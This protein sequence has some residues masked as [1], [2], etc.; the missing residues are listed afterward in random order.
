MNFDATRTLS[1]IGAAVGALLLGGVLILLAGFDPVQAY[2]ALFSGA[3]LEYHGLASTLVKM[4]PLIL[5]GLAVAMPLRAGLFNIGAEGQIYLGGLLAAWVGLL[6]PAV[7]GWL[8]IIICSLAG[9]AGGALWGAIPGY[10]KAFRGVNEV[11]VSLLLNYVGIN[12]VSFFVSGPLMADGAPY[13]YSPEIRE[14]YWLVVML[15]GT[16]T[17]LGVAIAILLA[18][19]LAFVFRRTSFGLGLSII[20]HNPDAARYAGIPVRAYTV[21]S[22]AMGGGFAGLAG[23]FEVLGL[24]HRLFHLFSSGYGYD[25]VVVALLA[26]GNPLMILISSMFLGGLRTGANNMQRVAGVPVTIVESLQGLLVMFVAV[27]LVINFSARR[28]GKKNGISP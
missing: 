12:L 2:A 22:L 28:L 7:P 20:G 8:G 10:F 19:L 16:D 4:S 24:K 26:S 23:A 13:P 6:L 9:V 14:Q 27:S 21:L 11:I 18:I 1:S 5:A 25:G 15:P 17:H 3:F